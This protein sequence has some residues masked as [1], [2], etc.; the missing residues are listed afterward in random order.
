VKAKPQKHTRRVER[1]AQQVSLEKQWRTA[2]RCQPSEIAT[3]AELEACFKLDLVERGNDVVKNL[4]LMLLYTKSAKIA[5]AIQEIVRLGLAGPDWQARA[6]RVGRHVSWMD[7]EKLAMAFRLFATEAS[8]S[9]IA[10]RIAAQFGG[11][12][13]FKAASK[14]EYRRLRRLDAS[15][16]DFLREL[17]LAERRRAIKIARAKVGLDSTEEP[18]SKQAMAVLGELIEAYL[19]TKKAKDRG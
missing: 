1:T 3:Q 2:Q 4:I 12:L 19:N 7:L 6:A 13:S 8:V 14:A 18:T 15:V 16:M 10:N 5:G 11:G 9:E 17:P